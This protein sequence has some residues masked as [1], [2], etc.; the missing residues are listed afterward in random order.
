[1]NYDEILEKVKRAYSGEGNSEVT[2]IK[3][4]IAVDM[5]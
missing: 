4:G 5:L 3:L 2:T 1:M